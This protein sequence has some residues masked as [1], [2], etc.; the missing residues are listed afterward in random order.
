MS[1]VTASFNRFAN[2]Y[3]SPSRQ[4]M[5]VP[6][7]ITVQ[8]TFLSYLSPCLLKSVVVAWRFC[9]FP[10]SCSL[11]GTPQCVSVINTE[12]V[13]LQCEILASVTEQNEK[14]DVVSARTSTKQTT[15]FCF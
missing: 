3:K 4:E 2:L 8:E 10:N 15:N 12:S 1:I 5:T 9:G 11:S 7:K 13:I 14:R 6:F